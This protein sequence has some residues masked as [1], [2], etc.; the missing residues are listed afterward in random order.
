MK[1]ITLFLLVFSLVACQSNSNTKQ[2]LV[3]SKDT[4]NISSQAYQTFYVEGKPEKAI[5]LLKN[6]KPQSDYDTA[7][8]ANM[9]GIFYHSSNKP[10]EAV[11]YLK[12]SLSFN[13]FDE[14]RQI[15]IHKLLGHALLDIKQ[16]PEAEI[17][18]GE[19]AKK[20]GQPKLELEK[21][22]EIHQSE[23]RKALANLEKKDTAA[24]PLMTVEPIY[25][26]NAQKQRLEGF[27]EMKFTIDTAGNVSNIVVIDS[28][29]KDTFEKAAIK[30]LSAWVYN[31]KMK[32]GKPIESKDNTVKI[33]F[34]AS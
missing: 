1:N 19:A 17:H 11:P 23:K 14:Q 20:S 28:S 6:T 12:K 24:T 4:T 9:I 5:L 27:V 10:A 31:P 32:S 25:P 7:H 29:P 34:K 8:I 16:Y 15:R 2:T 13:L 3:V 21:L 26:K 30:A 18:L 33:T 22:I